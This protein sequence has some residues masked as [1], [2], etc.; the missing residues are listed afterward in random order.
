MPSILAH[1]P[2]RLF[3]KKKQQQKSK[4][5]QEFGYFSEMMVFFC[6][7]KAKYTVH[8]H[9]I[10]VT[11]TGNLLQYIYFWIKEQ[12]QQQQ[13]QNCKEKYKIL[14]ANKRTGLDK[15]RII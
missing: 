14:F 12:Q 5:A 3:G 8:V 13:K 7:C 10:M 11:G 4:T 2:F 6:A 15:R 9:W 1:I